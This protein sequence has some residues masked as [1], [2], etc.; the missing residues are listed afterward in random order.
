MI[1]LVSID[2]EAGRFRRY[3]CEPG[4]AVKTDDVTIRPDRWA[5]VLNGA[6]DLRVESIEVYRLYGVE[7]V[8]TT[9]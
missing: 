6:A 2:I 4:L 3:C 9:A 1:Q 5:E 8:E 7:A